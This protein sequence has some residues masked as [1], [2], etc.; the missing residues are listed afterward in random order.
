[1]YKEIICPPAY[2]VSR[3]K[4][5]DGGVKLPIRYILSYAIGI[6]LLLLFAIPWFTYRIL[7]IGNITGLGVGILW[8]VITFLFHTKSDMTKQ[9]WFR[10]VLGVFGI[11]FLIAAIL[12]LLMWNALF[13]KPKANATVIVLGA[14]VTGQ[15]PSLVLE[16]RLIA[17]KAYLDTHPDV[18]AILSGGQGK[19]EIISEAQGMYQYLVEKGVQKDRLIKEDQSTTTYENLQYS[20]DIIKERGLSKDL[21][22]VSN[23][24]HIYRALWIARSMGLDAK[25]VP[26]SSRWWLF[27]TYYV[28]EMYAILYEWM[29]YMIQ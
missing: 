25:S 28:R 11:I 23:N 20:L 18:V 3:C 27:P 24:F 9:L 4:E 26:A 29:R 2:N 5:R 16:E 10:L 19:D 12:S 17:A 21:A 22:I 8:M 7:N 15:R 6:V 13:Q 1:M 14:K